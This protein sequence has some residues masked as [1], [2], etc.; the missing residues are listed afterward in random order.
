MSDAAP[1]EDSVTIRIV[2]EGLSPLGISADRIFN[3]YLDY[4]RVKIIAKR[5]PFTALG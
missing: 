5:R 4:P 1:A 2:L 3:Q